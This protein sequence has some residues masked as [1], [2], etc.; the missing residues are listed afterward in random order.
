[1]G[2]SIINSGEEGGGGRGGDGVMFIALQ[3]ESCVVHCTALHYT[4]LYFTALHYIER[5]HVNFS[6]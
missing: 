3:A 6:G 1:M 5:R 2:R 4:V